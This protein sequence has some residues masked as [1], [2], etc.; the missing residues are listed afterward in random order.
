MNEHTHSCPTHL[1]NHLSFHA[2]E[3]FSLVTDFEGWGDARDEKSKVDQVF[4]AQTATGNPPKLDV[5]HPKGYRHVIKY[6]IFII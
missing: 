1:F 2:D 4:K 5:Q 6:I 3:L